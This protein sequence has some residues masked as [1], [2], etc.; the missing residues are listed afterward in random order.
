MNL[1]SSL[2]SP[3]QIKSLVLVNRAVMPPMGTILGNPDGTVILFVLF[4]FQ[5]IQ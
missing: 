5:T 1:V 2:F 3:L 4:D